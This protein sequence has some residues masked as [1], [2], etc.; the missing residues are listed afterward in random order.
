MNNKNQPYPIHLRLPSQANWIKYIETKENDDNEFYSGAEYP[1]YSDISVIGEISEGLGPYALLNALP[2]TPGNQANISVI[3]RAFNYDNSNNY[4]PRDPL[5]TDIRRFHGGHFQEEIA[6]LLSLSLGIRLKAGEANRHFLPNEP[7]GRYRSYTLKPAPTLDLDHKNPIIPMPKSVHLTEAAPFLKTIPNLKPE[8]YIELVRA[9]R[10]YQDALWIS[11]SDP[12]LAWLLFVS[13]L[14][15]ASNAD[16]TSTG[17]AL[18][19]FKE[20]KPDLA[21]AIIETGGNDLLRQIAEDFK[22]I[23]GSTKKFIDFCEKFMPDA[24]NTRPLQAEGRISWIW[25]DIKPILTKIY[26]L[27]SKALH[28]GIP[29]PAPMC[30][31]P[32]KC[33]RDEFPAE[34]AITALAE[35]TQNGNWLPK[36]APIALHTFQHFARGAL[37]NWWTSISN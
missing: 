35:S 36:D 28:A 25:P 2:R 20:Y 22:G 1:L 23:F 5:K 21:L 27:R 12:H 37:L 15:I 6:A 14:E 13:S 16:F 33:Y 29:F 4:I 34:I 9:A 11:E 31:Q 7:Y 24:P 30:R 32:D 19:N 17:S 8:I 3:L 26:S 10:V 18:D